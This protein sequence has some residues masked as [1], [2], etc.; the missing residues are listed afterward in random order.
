MINDIGLTVARAIPY[1]HLAGL[2]GGSLTVHGGV[3]RDA[4]GRIVSHLVLPGASA[5]LNAIPG[6]G[7]LG[8]LVNGIQLRALS[9]DVAAVKAAT[10]QVLN[11][12]MATAALSGLGLATSLTGFV[13]MATR[14]KRIDQKLGAV[15]KQTKAIRKFLDSA[16]HAQLSNAVDSL[17]LAQGASDPETRRHLLVQCKQSFGTLAHQYRSLLEDPEEVAELSATEDCYVLAAIGSVTTTSDLGMFDDARDEM[18]RYQAEWQSIARRHCGKLVLKD[19]PARLLDPRYLKAVPTHQLIRLLDFTNNTNKGVGWMDDLRETLGTT[20]FVRS[21]LSSTDPAHI[22]YASKLLA[23][24][25]TLDGFVAH[26][27]FLAEQKVSLSHFAREAEE[28]QK[29]SGGEFLVLTPRS[30]AGA[31]A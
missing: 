20:T 31:A 11:Y 30:M 4:G 19:E 7:L 13:Y 24:D 1:E 28:L 25:E 15:E 9:T 10:E 5:A 2:L 6:A 21:A 16:Q 22:A 3:I 18:K 23:K 26:M 29:R 27:A 12:S 17:K 8:S 14:L